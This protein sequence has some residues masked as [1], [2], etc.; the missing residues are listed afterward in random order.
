[1]GRRAIARTSQTPGKTR[2]C[3]VFDVE[4]RYYLVDLPGYGY[5][6]VSK[7][8]RKRL[9]QL[10]HRYV[11]ERKE[12]MGV[13]WLLDIRR[14]PSAED[15]AMAEVFDRTEMSVLAVITKADKI[16]RG[17]RAGRLADIIG[18]LGLD[19][20]QTMVTSAHTN[21]GIEDLRSSIEHF[22]RAAKS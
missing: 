11:D 2:L 18:T 22:V 9:G 10:I 20:E 13:A 16:T 6:K 3:N 5:A 8:E 1:M 19:E 7:D 17:K 4:H 12:L 14:T 21:E 15:Q